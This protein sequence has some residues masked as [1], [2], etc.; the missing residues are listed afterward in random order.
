M[1]AAPVEQQKILVVEDDPAVRELFL[2]VLA[3]EKYAVHTA[4]N[5]EE[6]LTQTRSLNPDLI[7]L[8]IHMPK[9]DG[10]SFCKAIRD[11]QRTQDIPVIFITAYNSRERREEAIAAGGDDFMGKPFKI[12]ELMIRIRAML[13]AKQIT[14]PLE[15]LHQYIQSVRQ[16]RENPPPQPAS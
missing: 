7:L 16:M 11:D 4:T 8:D 10:V 9:L 14:D 2:D 15:R 5:G 3:T 12:D 1:T 13:K 6:A